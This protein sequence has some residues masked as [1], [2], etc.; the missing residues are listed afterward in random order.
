MEGGVESELFL[1]KV[2]NDKGTKILGIKLLPA[3]TTYPIYEGPVITKYAQTTKRV[4]SFNSRHLQD[5][6]TFFEPEQITYVNAGFYGA[7]ML[8][9]RGYLEPS[10]RTWNQLKNL[11]DS[12]IIYR[13]VRAPERRLWNVEAGRLPPGKSEEF[14]KQQ[15]ARYKKEFTINNDGTI[16]SQKLFQALTHDYWFIK[17]EGQGTEVTNLQS[18]INL[19][20]IDDVNYFLRK[21]YKTLQIPRSRWEDTMNTVA[22]NMAPG[23]LTREEVKFSRFIGRLRDRFKKIFIDLLVTQLRLSNQIDSKYTRESI[24]DIEFCEENVFAEQKRLMNLKSKFD[25]F[26]QYSAD[27]VG[28]DNPNGKFSKR[29]A[30]TKFFGWTDEEYQENE[31]WIKEENLANENKEGQET[32]Q[33]GQEPDTGTGQELGTARQEGGAEEEPP[34]QMAMDDKNEKGEPSQGKEAESEFGIP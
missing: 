8:D 12:L 11:E 22:T 2:L 5:S 21:M 1:E 29:L 34:E 14:L 25:V 23:E 15:I 18:G 28:P 17:R 33:D 26:A 30:M 13:L 27:I 3:S 32:P 31:E 9:V 10:I 7:N 4:N 19:G 16:D 20:E 24:F 6:E